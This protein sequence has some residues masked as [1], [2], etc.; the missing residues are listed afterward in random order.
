MTRTVSWV[1]PV[2]EATVAGWELARIIEASNE[3]ARI[4]DRGAYLRVEAP[5]CCRITRAE[6]ERD[7]HRPFHLPGDLE[8]LMPA[9]SGFLELNAQSVTWSS[10]PSWPG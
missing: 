4:L 8:A 6:I 10:R 3:G 7:L 2:L 1:G 9:F 5:A